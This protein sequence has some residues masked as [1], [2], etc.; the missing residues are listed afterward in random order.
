MLFVGSVFTPWA[1]V[2]GAV[3]VAIATIGWFWPRRAE[4]AE[5]TLLEQRS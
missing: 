1:M 4:A 2:W 5:A 3:P